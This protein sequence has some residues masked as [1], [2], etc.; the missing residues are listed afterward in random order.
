MA[1]KIDE[2]LTNEKWKKQKVLSKKLKH[3]ETKKKEEMEHANLANVQKSKGQGLDANRLF[4]IPLL[5]IRSRP[6]GG[7]GPKPEFDKYYQG[8]NAKPRNRRREHPSGH[9]NCG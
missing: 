1:S 5:R 9:H 3:E 7:T 4:R 6:L 2:L 8:G